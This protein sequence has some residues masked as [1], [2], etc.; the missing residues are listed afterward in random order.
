MPGAPS[1][2]SRAAD[3]SWVATGSFRVDLPVIRPHGEQQVSAHN[4]PSAPRNRTA[5]VLHQR[6]FGPGTKR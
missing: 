4:R 1:H 6:T 3:V 2:G 5:V